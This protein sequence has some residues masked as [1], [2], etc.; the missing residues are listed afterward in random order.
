METFRYWKNNK[1]G[2]DRLYFQPNTE[3][4]GHLYLLKGGE[5]RVGSRQQFEIASLYHLM[6]SYGIMSKKYSS[7]DELIEDLEAKACKVVG[8]RKAFTNEPTQKPEHYY[9]TSGV[10]PVP[11]KNVVM[12]NLTV[13]SAK[14][15]YIE[16]LALDASTIKFVKR[17]SKVDY[18]VT[19]DTRE[20]GDD[21]ASLFA[22]AG[23]R[24]V[25]QALPVGDIKITNV[26]TQDE[27]L[28]ERKTAVD[29]YSSVTSHNARGHN[30]AERMFNY[31]A[32]KAAEGIR[33]L[34]IWMVEAS[35]D[36]QRSMYRAF[37]EIKHVDGWIGYLT[38][39]L[40]QHV[41]EC[42]S[43]PHLVYL[44][45]KLM[46]TYFEQELYYKIKSHE[47]KQGSAQE[48]RASLL[49]GIASNEGGDHG[50]KQKDPNVI[51]R[52]L[53]AIPSL[54]AAAVNAIIERGHTLSDVFNYSLDDWMKFD[55]IG[56]VLA[57]K[58]MD[59]VALLSGK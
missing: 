59:E 50:V 31:Q 13:K 10:Q 14:S 3:G 28:I 17:N 25:N 21:L 20:Q 26:N 43:K 24:V 46:Q 29:L 22:G 37:P 56:K 52:V 55:G 49:G 38:G 7:M 5:V 35:D 30:Q 2:A 1:G 40:G 4:A 12:P 27:I 39:I 23:F 44:T 51:H 54:R 58:I 53:S 45:V 19:V 9:R 48:L 42:F 57:A 6:L 34:S 32:N 36:G 16:S 11:Q 18:T 47:R 33:V 41:I 15:L 8:H